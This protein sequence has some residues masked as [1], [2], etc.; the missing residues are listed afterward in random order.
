MRSRNFSIKI[1]TYVLPILLFGGI[2]YWISSF[3]VDSQWIHIP[4]KKAPAGV[5]DLRL[6]VG[7]STDNPIGDTLLVAT[8]DGGTFSFTLFEQ[9]W[10]ESSS[11]NLNVVDDS[12]TPVWQKP[13]EASNSNADIWNP[14]PV[15]GKVIDSVGVRFERPLS[16]IVRCYVLLEDGRIDIWTRSD[17][18]FRLMF[19]L[20]IK[21]SMIIAGIFIG[22]F[23]GYLITNSKR[24]KSKSPD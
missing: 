11:I 5:E 1:L 13:E 22:V 2:G 18:V 14:P 12:C 7:S 3:F 24:R 23:T 9:D 16:L 8:S 20:A 21:M 6:L 15:K 10:K 19:S 17:D 4:I